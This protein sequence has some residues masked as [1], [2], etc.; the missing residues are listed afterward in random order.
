[1][2][3]YPPH[4]T[5]ALKDALTAAYWYKSQQKKF[6]EVCIEDNKHI[7]NTIDWDAYKWAISSEIIDIL[8]NLQNQGL[9]DLR[10]LLQNVCQ[11]SDFSH[12][13]KLEDGKK[14]AA[15]AEVFIERLRIEVAKHDKALKDEKDKIRK[16]QEVMVTM[17]R[18]NVLSEKLIALK[19]EYFE[20]ASTKN[21]AQRGYKLETF[22]QNLFKLFDLDPRASFRNV[23]E[24]I[25]GSFNLDGTDFI[26]EAKW[27][28]IPSPVGDLDFFH[29]KITRKLD[30]TLGLFLSINGF[31]DFAV[32]AHSQKRSVILLMDGMDLMAVL[33]KRIEFDELI[34]RKKR[35]AAETGSI[36][37]KV[38]DML[39]A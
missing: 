39:S 27:Q 19:Q 22:M 37:Y 17:S 29:G 36:Y 10:R 16:R 3:I 12:L 23:G 8:D 11:I 28:D 32:Q 1:M 14:K 5:N 35:H 6:I 34:R 33:D 38:N 2:S 31:A 9:G 4:V 30:N 26:F 24:Q 25:D 20:I 13:R 21:K 15:E 18:A 7:L